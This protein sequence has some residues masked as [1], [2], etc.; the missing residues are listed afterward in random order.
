MEKTG[1]IIKN[2]NRVL[3]GLLLCIIM[4]TGNLN[5]VCAED[6]DS[7][8]IVKVGFFAFDGYH[9]MDKDGKRSGY[10][11]DFLRMAARY[12]DVDYQYVGYDKSW[13]EIQDMLK[14]GEID[15]LTSVQ[16][17]PEREEIF[18]FSKPI[19]TSSAI[20]T[21]RRSNTSIVEQDYDTYN[22]MRVGMLKE[23]SRND[24]F[25]ELALKNGFTYRPV[26]YNRESD[27]KEA[28]QKGDVDTVLTSSLR[29]IQ[30]ERIIEK[31]ATRD[32]YAAV[33]KGNTH[34][35]NEINYAIDQLN[36]AEGDWTDSLN[37]KY[38]G[39]TES[40]TLVFSDREKEI[41]KQY[42]SGE[43]KLTATCSIDREPY[44]YVENGELKGII[45]D[46][47]EELM[48]YAGIPYEIRIPKDRKEYEQWQK[49]GSVDIFMDGRI[50]TENETE[51]KGIAV[52]VPYMNFGIALLTRRDFD[53]N[54]RKLAVAQYQGTNGIEDSIAE[55]AE[56]V[57]YDSRE[58]AMEAVRD[59]KADAAVVYLYTALRF[60]NMD[61]FGSVTY[62]PLDQP[63][64]PHRICIMPSVSHELSGI[65]TKCIYA[66]PESKMQSLIS[67]YTAYKAENVTLMTFIMLYPVRSAVCLLLL[68]ALLMYAMS[69]GTKLRE[70]QKMLTVEKKRAEEKDILAKLA[71]AANESKTRFLFNMSHDIRTPL[72]AV[73]G[74][75]NLAKESIGD[76]DKERDYLDKIQIS[77]EHLLEIVND[78]LEMSRVES[79]NI[80]LDEKEC[81]LKDVIREA[82]ILTEE[83]SRK[84][85]Q[86]FQV[87]IAELKHPYVIC[88][89]LRIREILVHLL[90]N[91]VKFTPENGTITL[92]VKQMPDAKNEGYADLSICVRDNGCGMTS[93][94]IE[95][96]FQPFEREK[97]ATV[98]GLDGTG[99]GLAV[100]K[101]YVDAMNG[102]IQV[103]SEVDK[104]TEF[105]VILRQK[106]TKKP[107]EISEEPSL[108]ER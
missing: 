97:T 67:E 65:L 12:L 90:E 1:K 42:T 82:V 105:T 108:E 24:D 101:R 16:K 76:P 57:L 79:G 4:I 83:E 75:T 7:R 9:M 69:M 96:L 18:D 43:K 21:V 6:T 19:G 102:E 22:N 44:S 93:S 71:R 53:G 59:G 28:L 51:A 14:D 23:N 80:K 41:I 49:D 107:A 85:N 81:S 66:F 26:Y 74:F 5:M 70:R 92:S 36:Q 56:R 40:K 47:F 72:N 20:L 61:S 30:N 99:I 52:T 45:P 46:M 35:L 103:Q 13:D 32:F 2:I 84:K 8:E 95:N 68:V 27:L 104:G 100:T 98:S 17:T 63:V 38:Y 86:K 48:G 10:G 106:L 55:D 78:V 3:T 88:D 62:T 89:S 31:F 15:L 25:A 60:V 50:E 29:S 39:Q 64:Y 58:S 91:A 94:F 77:G 54:I 37:Y 34:L 11:Y 87:D 33:K 73:L